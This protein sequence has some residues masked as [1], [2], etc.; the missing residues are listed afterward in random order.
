MSAAPSPDLL[1]FERIDASA[2]TALLRVVGGEWEEAPELVV[3]DGTEVRHVRA[4]PRP[5]GAA[6]AYTVDREM[7]E[8]PGVT[9]ALDFGAER[10]T[11][12]QPGARVAEPAPRATAWSQ[13]IARLNERLEQALRSLR[14]AER[15]RDEGRLHERKAILL[16]AQLDEARQAAEARAAD[17]QQRT[18]ATEALATDL[19]DAQAQLATANAD[20]D[21][22]RSQ[23]SVADAGVHQL[24]DQLV[25][26]D[27][28][29]A[30]LDHVRSQLAAAEADAAGL[31]EQLA[32][33][34][35]SEELDAA[36]AQLNQLYE[37]L[38][39]AEARGA[40]AD[41]LRMQLEAITTA[42]DEAVAELELLRTQ[43]APE[44][45]VADEDEVAELRMRAELL[46]GRVA[47]V[48]AMRS[49]R[50]EELAEA[51]S[52]LAEIEANGGEPIAPATD[53]EME[54]ELEDTR[55]ALDAARR[56]A[57][58]AAEEREAVIAD[59]NNM[60]EQIQR[61]RA[62]R[63]EARKEIEERESE[64]QLARAE[65]AR[66]ND[67]LARLITDAEDDS[68]E[69]VDDADAKVR[70]FAEQLDQPR[71]QL[72][73][74]PFK[75]SVPDYSAVSIPPPGARTDAGKRGIL[76]GRR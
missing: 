6:L 4:L 13:E 56:E 71:P 10:V 52:R 60:R 35:P 61:L 69:R 72:Q 40:E 46:S 19:Q 70:H 29:G 57:I 64:M 22:V 65:A 30:E 18:P 12:P 48:E 33:G 74:E 2:A 59:V 32:A 15:Q 55:V 25:V 1:R 41:L 20:L 3:G 27:A 73:P 49:A 45:S 76:P 75:P 67:R 11:L 54:R 58:E 43:P 37:H 9:F 7:L 68:R 50:E 23:L 5:S 8:H 16:K 39:N 66:A 51:Y 42:R 21:H 63:D 26:A 47:E 36:E 53:E 38:A 17:L 28:R 34:V 31:R 44:P 14:E 24:R 62:E